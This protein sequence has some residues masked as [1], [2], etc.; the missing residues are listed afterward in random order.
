[1]NAEFTHAM[2]RIRFLTT[3]EGGRKGCVASGYRS[4]FSFG[5]KFDGGFCDAEI[6]TRNH[7]PILLGEEAVVSLRFFYPELLRDKLNTGDAFQVTEGSKIVAKGVI[8]EC[9]L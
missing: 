9:F 4:M 8:E 3:S 2:A 1:M 6:D 7:E 5:E